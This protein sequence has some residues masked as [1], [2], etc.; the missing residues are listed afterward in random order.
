MSDEIRNALVQM[1]AEFESHQL[2]IALV[3][4][5]HTVNVGGMVR[6][7]IGKNAAWYRAFCSRHSSDRIRRNAASDTRI[8][9]RNV[10]RLLKRLVDGLGSKSKYAPE[11]VRLAERTAR[12]E[13]ERRTA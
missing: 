4:C 7:A 6:V 12:R 3:P 5:R 2:E 13:C 8:K 11:L 10:E 9:R 1:Q